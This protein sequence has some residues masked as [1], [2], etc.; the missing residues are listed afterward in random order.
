MWF[1][2]NI[3]ALSFRYNGHK[4]TLR[5]IFD[6]VLGRSSDD[7]SPDRFEELLEACNAIAHKTE[8]N[9]WRLRLRGQNSKI[10]GP[11]SGTPVSIG[12]IRATY[13]FLQ[14]VGLTPDT[15]TDF[16]V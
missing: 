4:K 7:I 16:L 11:V 3:A 1:K 6:R 10:D 9:G 5:L 12:T 13:T 14:G 15:V 2:R 8:G